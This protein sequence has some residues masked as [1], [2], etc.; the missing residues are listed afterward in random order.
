[1]RASR[2]VSG[3]KV[4]VSGAEGLF[5]SHAEAVRAAT[6]Y[7]DRALTH[8]RGRPDDVSVTVQKLSRK[9][10]HIQA[11]PL[12]TIAGLPDPA[13][14]IVAVRRLLGAVGVG[15]AAVGKALRIIGSGRGM[16]GAALISVREARR[17]EP[18]R[19]RGVRASR[20][21]MDAATRE[22][23]SRALRRHGINTTQVKEALVLATKV[24]AGNGVVAELCASDDPDYTTGYVA[25]RKFGYVRIPN[26]KPKGSLSGGRVFLVREGV[27]VARLIKYLQETPVLLSGHSLKLRGTVSLNDVLGRTEG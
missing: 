23:L 16:R 17:L 6:E 13:H 21:G 26:I 12:L 15:S 22:K 5:D 4:H 8:P 20:L 14:A 25:T 7:T 10:R 11:L 3:R 19:V 24:L 18:D 2:T 27:N 9:P 1:M